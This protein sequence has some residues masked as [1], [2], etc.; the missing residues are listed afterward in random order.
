MQAVI[1]E[2]PS[3][4]DFL[5]DAS[6]GH[7]ETLCAGLDAAGIGYRINPRLV[8]GLDYYNRTVFE[9]ITDALGAQGTVCAGGRYDGLVGQLGGRETPAVGFAM[10][11]ER[12]I[13]LID[14]AAIPSGPD[15]YLVAV[16]EKAQQEAPLL[17]DRLRGRMPALRLLCHCG[18]GSFKS[19]FKKA[20]RSGARIALVLGDDELARGCIGVKPL[21]GDG[22]QQVVDLDALAETLAARIPAATERR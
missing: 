1:A 4:I 6:R 15:V 14:A 18:G 7:F 9:W 21:R 19:Q 10:G 8:R 20:D 11:V 3:L 12:L 16:G 22:E 17:A 2:A 5:S 13:E